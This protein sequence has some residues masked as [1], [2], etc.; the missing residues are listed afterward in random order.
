[1]LDAYCTN[2]SSPP[3]ILVE[4][5]G[6]VVLLR[7]LTAPARQWIGENVDVRQGLGDA[8]AVEPR[9]VAN[10]VRGAIADGL[11]VR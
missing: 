8:I 1:M 2:G 7:P 10:I 3:D 4:N 9:Y 5:H 11:R 6:S